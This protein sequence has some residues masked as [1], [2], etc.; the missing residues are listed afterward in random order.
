MRFGTKPIRILFSK[1]IKMKTPILITGSNGLLGSELV[2]YFS[3]KYGSSNVSAFERK[4]LDITDRQK[5]FQVF[6]DC[7]PGITINAAAYTQVDKAEEEKEEA[8]RINSMG[9]KTLTE[10][11]QEY[12]TKLVH[13]STDQVLDGSLG[14][15][16]IET[17]PPN[18]LNYYAKTKLWGEQHALMAPHSLI[19]RVQWLY[20]KKRDRFTPLQGKKEFKTFCDQWGAPTDSQDV[21]EWTSALLERE[22]TGVFHFTY[23]DYASWD[24]I[25]EFAKSILS[26]PTILIPIRTEDAQLPAKRPHF[27]VLSNA[28]LRS[29]LGKQELGSWKTA[30]QRFLKTKI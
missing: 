9:V 29:T 5:V 23:D 27:S 19:L 21:A 7:R 26:L 16:Q 17:D 4:Q 20:G 13:Y 18:P 2:E 22:A 24:Q 11:C 6:Q 3:A 14:R 8:Y 1:R 10:A 28:K 15:P 25:F 30:L 12:R